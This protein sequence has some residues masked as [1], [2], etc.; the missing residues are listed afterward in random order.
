[1]DEND[2]PPMPPIVVIEPG[3]ILGGYKGHVSRAPLYAA[4][5][6][7]GSKGLSPDATMKIKHPKVFAAFFQ[8]SSACFLT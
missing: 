3:F 4:T 1:M 2:R 7:G 5:T 6:D 8:K